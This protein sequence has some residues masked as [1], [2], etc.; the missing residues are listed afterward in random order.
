MP[1]TTGHQ[2]RLRFLSSFHIRREC[3]VLE[4][5]VFTASNIGN[6]RNSYEICVSREFLERTLQNDDRAKSALAL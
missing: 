1:V 6:K 3:V 5:F 4:L 2:I